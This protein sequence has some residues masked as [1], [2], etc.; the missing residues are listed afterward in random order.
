MRY[1]HAKRGVGKIYLAQVF[2]IVGFALLALGI[3]LG[4]IGMTTEGQV[5]S[6]VTAGLALGGL[7]SLVPGVIIPLIAMVLEFLGLREARLDEP[8]YLGK[9]YILVLVSIVLCIVEGFITGANINDRGIFDLIGQLM[10]LFVFIYTIS[11][12]SNL[13]ARVRRQ[14]QVIKGNQIMRLFIAAQ[15]AELIGNLLGNTFF[16]DFVSLLASIF[17]IVMLIQYLSFLRTAKAAL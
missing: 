7:L 14:D 10:Q 15:V 11:G 3:G 9:A 4:A 1:K 8:N 5:S 12:I 13:M 16:G 6:G 17:S 2:E